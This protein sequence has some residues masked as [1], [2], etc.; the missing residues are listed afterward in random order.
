MVSEM[1]KVHRE[2]KLKGPKLSFNKVDLKI[3]KC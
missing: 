2:P 1:K 3:K